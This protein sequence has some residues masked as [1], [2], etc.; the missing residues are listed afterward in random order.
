MHSLNDHKFVS[1]ESYEYIGVTPPSSKINNIE[2]AIKSSDYLIVVDDDKKTMQKQF[3]KSKNLLSAS[4]K[5]KTMF[6]EVSDST[7]FSQ[8]SKKVETLLRKI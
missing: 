5:T 2:Q 1:K 4:K 8:I 3:N 6:L 7:P